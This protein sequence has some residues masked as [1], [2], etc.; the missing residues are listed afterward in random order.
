MMETVR[1][2]PARLARHSWH[3]ACSP[4]DMAL[5]PFSCALALVLG[6]SATAAGQPAAPLPVDVTRDANLQAYIQ[7]L[8]S[9][10][11]ANKS[12][13]VSEVMQF[14]EAEDG[15]FWPVYR[16]YESALAKLNDERMRLVMEFAGTGGVVTDE[17]ADRTVKEALDLESRRHALLVGYYEKL[18]KA[19][20]ART[21]ARAMQ[22]E[23]QWLLLLDLQIAS[24]LPIA[25]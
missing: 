2:N 4:P 13:L 20:P 10:L 21:A 14:T 16:E 19:L 12:A 3:A 15:K 9:D 5:R 25:Q 6:F 8:R 23:R 24:A 11:R 22:V 18:K 17:V 7:L 1:S